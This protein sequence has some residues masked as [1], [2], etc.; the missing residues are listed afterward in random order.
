MTT[1]GESP[2][3]RR[4]GQAGLAWNSLNLAGEQTLALSSP[5][6]ENEGTIPAVHA[7]TRVGG[8]DLSPALTW[9]PAPQ[10]AA[11]LLL[12]V[13]DPDAPTPMPFVHCV[14]LLDPSLTGLAHGALDAATDSDGVRVLRSGIGSGYFGPAPPKSHGPHLYVFQLFALATPLTAASS[15]ALESAK[16]R[17][18]LAAAGN[19]LARGRLDGFYQRT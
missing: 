2:K 6:F 3:R 1:S 15:G 7:S 8:K 16:P 9:S 14:A 13:E 5:D 18:V 19:V 10:E 17:E 4:A 12:V 11:Q